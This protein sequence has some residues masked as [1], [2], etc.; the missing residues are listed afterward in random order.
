M[1]KDLVA[2]TSALESVGKQGSRRLSKKLVAKIVKCMRLIT[3]ETQQLSAIE[4][5]VELLRNLVVA[6]SAFYV[7]QSGK[8]RSLVNEFGDI[9]EN[10][11][12]LEEST[13]QSMEKSKE[14]EERSLSEGSLSEKSLSEKSIEKEKEEEEVVEGN[15]ERPSCKISAFPKRPESP[16]LSWYCLSDKEVDWNENDVDFDWSE[17]GKLSGRSRN[18]IMV[19]VDS[20]APV[21][22]KKKSLSSNPPRFKSQSTPASISSSF[23][24]TSTSTHISLV[25]LNNT[26]ARSS[27]P[28]NAFSILR[29]TPPSSIP[30]SSSPT[31]IAEI[32]KYCE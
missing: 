31:N 21:K 26:N 3:A 23:F 5:N 10:K 20:F 14:E 29:S 8:F 4:A 7:E 11:E 1:C 32:Q 19:E 28:V 18:A 24:S 9:L 27:S 25:S 30:R 17:E 15:E 22:E 12:G 2:M 16:E 13:D 6:F